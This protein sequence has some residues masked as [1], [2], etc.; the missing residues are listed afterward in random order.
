MSH[1]RFVNK[2]RRSLNLRE[3]AIGNILPEHF[4]DLYPKFITMLKKYYEFQDQNDSTELPNHL[5]ATRDINETDITLL[6]Y[7]EDELLLG[8]SYFQKFGSNETELR[9]AANF[10]NTLFRSKGSKFAIEW[11]F[12]SFYG[13]DVEVLY[14]KENVF[15][16]GETDSQIGADSLKYITDDKLYQTFALLIR[17]GVPIA[18][19][20]ETFKL[21]V[22]PAGMYLGGEVF[23]VD[24]V[25]VDLHAL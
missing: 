6:T 15:K 20:R 22:H 25:T 8:E 19:W 10:S 3:P 12:R 21:F 11:F 23:I 13:E 14:P 1:E 18:K 2:R 7:I 24:D 16:I 4:A 17:V 9:A 5:F